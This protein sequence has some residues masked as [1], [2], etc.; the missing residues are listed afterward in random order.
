MRDCEI[1]DSKLRLIAT[2][3]RSI[4]TYGGQ[5]S[6]HYADELLDE[7]LARRAA[8]AVRAKARTHVPEPQDPHKLHR[9]ERLEGIR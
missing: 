7:R 6:S 4:R 2:V 3:R 9:D 8:D 5:L 1:I